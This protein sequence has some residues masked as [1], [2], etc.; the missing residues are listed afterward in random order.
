MKP[1]SLR[2]STASSSAGARQPGMDLGDRP[3]VE[4]GG[5][6]EA[7]EEI[8][9]G[10]IEVGVSLGVRAAGAG[11]EVVSQACRP[12]FVRDVGQGVPPPVGFFVR[13]LLGIE[14]PHRPIGGPDAAGAVDDVALVRGRPRRPARPGSPGSPGTSSC[15]SGAPRCRCA[16]P[17][18]SRRPSARPGPSCRPGHRGSLSRPGARPSPSHLAGS[19]PADPGPGHVPGCVVDAGTLGTA[20]QHGAHHQDREG[21]DHSQTDEHPGGGRRPGDLVR[22]EAND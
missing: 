4:R 18:T 2:M 13:D 10:R 1:W 9:A 16:C 14:H 8:L 15:R 20:A 12:H 7:G 22:E 19:T 5:E 6:Q 3:A 17:P 21:R 11:G